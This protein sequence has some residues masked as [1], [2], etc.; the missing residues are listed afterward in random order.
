MQWRSPEADGRAAGG[1]QAD[2][3]RALARGWLLGLPGQRTVAIGERELIHILPEAPLLYEIPRAPRHARR[4]LAWQAR[5]L[6]VLDLAELFH[7][8]ALDADTPLVG[9]VA[10]RAA[11]VA[12]L[13][14]LALHGVPR[15][16]ETSDTQSCEL[17]PALQALAPG[18]LS[19]LEHPDH[20]AVPILHL[21]ALF[22]A[23]GRMAGV[24]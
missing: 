18:C 17:P 9:V 12:R 11:G 5:I 3:P 2:T 13:G 8:A 6:P 19:C 24:A 14:A 22:S 7:A 16:F 10:Y 1:T 20:G 23:S 21:S 4:A 15:R